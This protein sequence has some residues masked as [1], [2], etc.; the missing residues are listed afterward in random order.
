M[1]SDN[2]SQAFDES[3]KP[4]LDKGKGKATDNTP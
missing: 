1:T 3:D 2:S 4:L